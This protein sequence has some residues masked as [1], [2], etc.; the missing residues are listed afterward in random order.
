MSFDSRIVL[1]LQDRANTGIEHTHTRYN[2][3]IE[4]LK[5]VY[6]PPSTSYLSMIILTEEEGCIAGR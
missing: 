3:V 4:H 6:Q 5:E 2:D 1:G